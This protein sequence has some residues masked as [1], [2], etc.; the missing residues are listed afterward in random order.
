MTSG[1]LHLRRAALLVVL[2]LAV[3]SGAMSGTPA[4]AAAPGPASARPARAMWLWQQAPAAE[5]IAWATAHDVR[6]LFVSFPPN[7]TD[8][9]WYRTLKAGADRAH[10]TLSA[11]GG[12][13]SW[14]SDQAAATRWV[15]AVVRTG[16]FTGLHVDVEPYT[17]PDWDGNRAALVRGYLDLLG[18][19]R[20]APLPVELDVP[21][22]YVTIAVPGGGNL[23]D[24]VL[25]RIS[26]L[27]VLTYR[28]TVSGPNSLLQVGQDMLARA[29]AGT[30][31]RLAVETQRLADC[32][33]CTFYGARQS[34]LTG[35]L[36]E[37]DRLAAGH[38]GYTGVAVHYYQAWRALAG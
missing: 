18:R 13:A 16:L 3:A 27:T 21:F 28:N 9:T 14:V 6:D 23:A 19:L 22:W 38:P 17:R 5:V 36:A 15:T 25:A 34:A 10:L 8:L 2:S 11:L 35:A 24:A 20:T 30:A 32:P 37:V 29:G 31:I 33:Y 12:D 1:L 7:T 4:G 26:R